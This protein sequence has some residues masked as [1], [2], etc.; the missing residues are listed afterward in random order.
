MPNFSNSTL[1]GMGLTGIILQAAIRL[2]RVET[3][4]IRQTTIPAANLRAVMAAFE[5]AS[6][7]TYWVAWIDCQSANENSAV[8]FSYSANTRVALTSR[9][10]REKRR[11]S[12]ARSGG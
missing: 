1:G 6:E 11:W 2:R 4:W 5:E 7:A 12:F 10:R 3:G 9:R 8:P